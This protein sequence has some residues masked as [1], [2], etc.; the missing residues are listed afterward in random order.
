METR[1]FNWID[2]RMFSRRAFLSQLSVASAVAL[3]GCTPMRILLKAY[4][5]KYEVDRKLEDAFLR[6][7]VMAVIPNAA[8]DEPHL[9]EMYKDRYYPFYRFSG[10]FTSDLAE[11]SQKLFG[12][13]RFDELS[14][15][16][17]TRVIQ[18]ALKSDAATVRIYQGAILMAQVSYYAGIYDDE[19]GCPQIEFYGSE[20]AASG[21][22]EPIRDSRLLLA[23]ELTG[24]GNPP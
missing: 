24:T 9:I 12:R 5:K 18:H 14:L 7:F 17:R 21:G 6:A 10:F 19:R 22:Q 4:P 13:D 11:R 2:S 16:E 23:H 20:W 3:V 1:N 8:P 15:A